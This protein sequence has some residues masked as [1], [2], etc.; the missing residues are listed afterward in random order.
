MIVWINGTFGVGKTSTATAL[1]EQTGWR[2][3]DPEHVGFL[4]A[5]NL[6]DQEFDDFQDLPPWR[7]LVP[8]VADRIYRYTNPDAMIAVQTVLVAD[9]WEE[10]LH[11]FADRGLPVCHVVLDCD[12]EELRRRI[13][14][15]EVESQ[16]LDWRLDHIA[17]YWA[18]R[19]WL[20]D[21]ADLVVDT[22]A[23]APEGAA[24]RIADTVTA[25]LAQRT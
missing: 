4:L 5:G 18:A 24:R 17:K 11:G 19:S 22:T 14:T 9:Y 15:D 25:R 21:A 12:E 16:A 20:D 10:L 1:L 8:A 7:E 23:L 13:T 3:F 6:R 2:L